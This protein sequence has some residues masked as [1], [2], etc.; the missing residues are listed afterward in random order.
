MRH[1]SDNNSLKMQLFGKDSFAVLEAF[2]DEFFHEDWKNCAVPVN[3]IWKTI[4]VEGHLLFRFPWPTCEGVTKIR[5]GV[6]GDLSD[7]IWRIISH[8]R[9]KRSGAAGRYGGFRFS[10]TR[11]ARKN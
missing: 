2:Y 6:A 5:F 10:P 1:F 4:Y 7:C 11:V 3:C 9:K 8:F